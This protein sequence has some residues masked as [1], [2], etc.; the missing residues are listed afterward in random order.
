MDPE[1][2]IMSPITRV[3]GQDSPARSSVVAVGDS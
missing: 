2:V 3:P 1:M